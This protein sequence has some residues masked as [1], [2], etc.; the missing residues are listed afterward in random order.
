VTL[1]IRDIFVN[2]SIVIS[3]L[4]VIHHLYYKYIEKWPSVLLRRI[5][6]GL[7][8]GAMGAILVHFQVNI[9]NGVQIDL[10]AFAVILAATMGGMVTSIASAVLIA[11]SEIVV[12]GVNERTIGGSVILIGISLFCGAL[13]FL[14]VNYWAKWFIMSLVN[15]GFVT[16]FIFAI[17]KL[18]ISVSQYSLSWLF[19]LIGI[20]I[21][22]Y[23]ALYLVNSQEN[24]IKLEEI[25]LKD[26]LTGLHNVRYF[27]EK[28][29]LCCEESFKDSSKPFSLVLIDIDYFKHVND[30]YGHQAG[31]LILIQLA[32]ILNKQCRATDIVSRNGGEEFSVLLPSCNKDQAY[33]LAE[34]IRGAVESSQFSISPTEHITITISAGI[35]SY[36]NQAAT[37]D[38]LFKL[39]DDALYSAKRAGRN[40]VCVAPG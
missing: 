33:T 32:G 9:D 13:S 36:N 19:S 40:Q 25:S 7:G 11:L 20:A 35:S 22:L 3:C 38:M 27:H 18:P 15:I 8:Y 31:D 30:T 2:T 39:A 28:M 24:Y 37:T 4:F 26:P 12:L 21:T 1:L 29:N 10:R 6:Y 34:R 14:R 23:F 5:F 17:A 16:V